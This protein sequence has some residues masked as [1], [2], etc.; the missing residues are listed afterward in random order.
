MGGL[1]CWWSVVCVCVFACKCV[2][3]SLLANWY[4]IYL[5]SRMAGSSRLCRG[6]PPSDLHLPDSHIS[7]SHNHT[8]TQS[9]PSDV[10]RKKTNLEGSV[11][12]GSSPG[13][14]RAGKSGP[15]HC[16]CICPGAL[17]THTSLQ[18]EH[19]SAT[20]IHTQTL[21]QTAHTSLQ[22]YTHLTA[23]CAHTRNTH[24]HF[25]ANHTCTHTLHCIHNT[26]LE[27]PQ[28]PHC[29]YAHTHKSYKH[30]DQ[31]NLT[32]DRTHTCSAHTH[33]LHCKPHTNTSL[34]TA[35]RQT[36]LQTLHTLQFPL[37]SFCRGDSENDLP[38]PKI[39]EKYI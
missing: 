2:Y 11:E 9:I 16:L 13:K 33:T 3:P 4:L 17:T 19:P 24:T 23:K 27:H 8:H 10:K 22:T 29:R 5:F 35:H 38:P 7:Y 32:T 15:W 28:I 39:I 34:Q 21:P 30:K 37:P 20:H 6:R 1:K 31:I 26:N 25:T 14:R 36:S 18:T 12:K